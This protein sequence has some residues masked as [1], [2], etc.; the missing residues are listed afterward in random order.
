MRVVTKAGMRETGA[1]ETGAA[2]MR[3]SVA[4]GGVCVVRAGERGR[5]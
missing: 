2:A 3:A 1:A 5:C 4:G